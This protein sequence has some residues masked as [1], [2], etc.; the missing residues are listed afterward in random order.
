MTT[1]PSPLARTSK[2]ES[3]WTEFVAQNPSIDHILHVCQSSV[4][5]RSRAWNL[6]CSQ[7]PTRE[8]VHNLLFSSK[9]Q[10]A[11]ELP[12]RWLMDNEPDISTLTDIVKQCESSSR[13]EATERLL[14]MDLKKDTLVWIVRCPHIDLP[15]REQ[16]AI[17]LQALSPSKDELMCIVSYCRTAAVTAGR[18]LLTSN[19]DDQ[20]I[21]TI[22]LRAPCLAVEIWDQHRASLG[23]HSLEALIRHNPQ[24]AFRFDVGKMLIS[25][26]DAFSP[27][28]AVFENIPELREEAWEKLQLIE[29]SPA[30]GGALIRVAPDFTDRVTPLM[31]KPARD[32]E[33]VMYEL[34]WLTKLD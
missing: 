26:T 9:F 21:S 4:R 3:L 16:A 32:V 1:P 7:S 27:L 23:I 10:H 2:I 19:Q 17:K 24:F 11:R 13:T 5:L 31:K 12:A 25:K 30:W 29:L 20:T 33:T 8:S 22:I 18:T 34:L 14:N 15:L 28:F 6:Y